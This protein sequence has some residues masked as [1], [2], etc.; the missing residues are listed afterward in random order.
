MGCSKKVDSMSL[1]DVLFIIVK[2]LYHLLIAL[3]GDV[4][5]GVRD[6]GIEKLSEV[7]EELKAMGGRE[8]G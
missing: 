7:L 1:I 2:V 6:I 8:N 5:N 3:Y 4:P